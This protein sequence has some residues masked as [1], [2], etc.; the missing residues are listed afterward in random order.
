MY[1]CGQATNGYILH[2]R[3]WGIVKVEGP[4]MARPANALNLSIAQLQRALSDKKSELD[5]LTRQRSVLQKKVDRIDRQIERLGGPGGAG[6]GGTGIRMRNERSLLEIMQEV[7]TNA[8]KPM[9][10]GDILDGVLASGYRSGSANFRG[11]I[12]QSLIKDNR[13][14]ATERGVYELKGSGESKKKAKP[15][16]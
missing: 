9:K 11:I 16:S 3:K 15:T 7:M 8:G 12:N 5:K 1:G 6:R 10:V 2:H 4:V 13:F 14:G